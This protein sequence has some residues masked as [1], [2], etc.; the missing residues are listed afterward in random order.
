MLSPYCWCWPN[1]GAHCP[2]AAM[3]AGTWKGR[4]CRVRCHKQSDFYSGNAAGD[5]AAEDLLPV[6]SPAFPTCC[7]KGGFNNVPHQ[8]GKLSNQ[9]NQE[10]ADRKCVSSIVCHCV[11]PV[12]GSQVFFVT[13]WQS[14][15]WNPEHADTNFG[16]HQR[17]KIGQGKSRKF[18][19]KMEW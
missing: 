11:I 14:Y 6:S 17:H 15:Y 10:G 19:A 8:A 2:E 18:T 12:Q 4:G 13:T 5:C 16:N 3:H 1:A 7:S 9:N